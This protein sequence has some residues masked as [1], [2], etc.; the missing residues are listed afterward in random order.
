[1]MSKVQNPSKSGTF[2]FV[3]KHKARVK[4]DDVAAISQAYIR[5]I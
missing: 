1:M 2:M 4:D 3:Q 5:E